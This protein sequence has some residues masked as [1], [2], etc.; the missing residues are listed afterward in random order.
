MTIPAKSSP[1]LLSLDALRGFTIAGMILVNVP[2]SWDH[3]YP[4]LRHAA[5]NGLTLADLVFPFFL[6]IVGA[7]LI[8]ALG[9]RLAQ[10]VP[11]QK[12]L[13]K[14]IYRT[15]VIFAL[16]LFL[17]GMS[18]QFAFPLRVAGVLQRIAL[19]Y[20]AG[21]LMF[22]Y[23]SHTVQIVIGLVL[24]FGYWIL[25]IFIPVPGHGMVFTPEMNWTAWVDGKILPGAMYF[26]TWDPEGVLSTLPA[27]VT[28]LLG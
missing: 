26:K 19:C 13:G 12:I 21:S 25:T 22:L 17:N 8:L 6:F 20:L 15:L 1:R 2:G 23:A 3:V 24:L 11:K 10:N 27:I 4:P 14:I 9:K 28:V 5:F 16:G 7:S 18:A